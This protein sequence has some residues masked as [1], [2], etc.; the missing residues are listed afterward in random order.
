MDTTHIDQYT[1]HLVGQGVSVLQIHR[2]A[3]T[4]ADHVARLERWAEIP[5]YSLVADLGCGVG[6]VA[7]LMKHLR[8]DLYFTLVNQSA[9]QL[10]YCPSGMELIEGDFCT[11][12]ENRPE[13]YDAAMFLFSIGHADHKEALKAAHQLLMKDGILF[14]YDMI[15]VSGDNKAMEE[16]QY[17]VLE[18]DEIEALFRSTGFKI[19]FF[20][21]P[22]DDG[23]YGEAML[24]ADFKRVFK[25]TKPAIW[26]LV[27]R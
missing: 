21:Q 11:T 24:G 5:A 1:E 19:D 8:P 23:Q 25:G 22:E 10:G 15:R 20:M 7:R 2:F 27:K 17:S 3:D 4:E 26:R 9:K 14:I 6:G 13:H 18:K 16:V 12:L